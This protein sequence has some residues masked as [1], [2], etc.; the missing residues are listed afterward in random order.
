[1]DSHSL[2]ALVGLLGLKCS[3]PNIGDFLF[4]FLFY[5]TVYVYVFSKC[6]LSTF[7]FYP[8]CKRSNA[9]WLFALP[10][11]SFVSLILCEWEFN[12]SFFLFCTN[13]FIFDAV[14]FAV[15]SIFVMLRQLVFAFFCYMSLALSLPFK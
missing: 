4:F 7:F 10:L 1:M 6:I 12:T 3:M 11:H 2:C 8:D 9:R 13:I 14:F 5:K 15:Q